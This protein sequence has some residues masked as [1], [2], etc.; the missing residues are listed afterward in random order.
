MADIFE[1]KQNFISRWLQKSLNRIEGGTYVAGPRSAENGGWPEAVPFDYVWS[2]GV[3]HSKVDGSMTMFFRTPDDVRT[4]WLNRKED[5]IHNQIFLNEVIEDLA[6]RLGQGTKSTTKDKRR[7][8]SLNIIRSPYKGLHW[9]K[10]DTAA[11]IDYRERM[12]QNLH[13]PEWSSYFGIELLPSGAMEDAASLQG[14]KQSMAERYADPL[15]PY[16]ADLKMVRALMVEDRGFEPLSNFGV[17]SRDYQLLTSWHGVDIEP[18]RANKNLATTRFQEPVDGYSLITPAWGEISFYAAV[19]TKERSDFGEDPLSTAAHWGKELYNPSNDVVG[20]WIKGEIRHRE[21][22][23]EVLNMKTLGRQAAWNKVNRERYAEVEAAERDLMVTKQ[24][25]QAAMQNDFIDNMEILVAV[26]DFV[27]TPNPLRKHLRQYGMDALLAVNRQADCLVAT[28][29]G[30]GKSISR[31][32]TG[33]GR[34][35]N[36]RRGVFSCQAFPGALS[37]SGILRR[38]KPAASNGILIGLTNRD[39]EYREVF[40][41]VDAAKKKNGS[42]VILVTGRTGSGKALSLQTPVCTPTGPVKLGDVH[43]GDIVLDVDGRPTVVT[44]ETE[45]YRAQAA[46]DVH[47][48]DGEVLVADSLHQWPVVGVEGGESLVD[49]ATRAMNA[50]PEGTVGTLEDIS[51]RISACGGVSGVWLTREALADSLAFIGCP[52]A[53]SEGMWPMREALASLVKRFRQ[54]TTI[55]SSKKGDFVKLSTMDLVRMAPHQS[56]VLVSGHRVGS[57]TPCAGSEAP[58]VKC[59][60]VDSPTCGFLVGE[61]VATGNTQSALQYITQVVYDGRPAIMLNPKAG[62]TLEAVFTHLGGVTIVINYEFLQENPGMLDPYNFFTETNKIGATLSDIISLSMGIGQGEGFK[63]RMMD[64]SIKADIMDNCR[65]SRNKTSYDVVYGNEVGRHHYPRLIKELNE[66]AKA[67]G[68]PEVKDGELSD[69]HKKYIRDALSVK[70]GTC[71]IFNKD[72]RDYLTSQQKVSPFWQSV[73]TDIP[74]PNSDL[75]EKLSSGKPVLIEWD[76]SLEMPDQDTDPKDYTAHHIESVVS[77]NLAFQYADELIYRQRAGGLL[78]VDEAWVLKGSREARNI[79]NR[80]AREWRQRNITLMLITQ[81]IQDYINKKSGNNAD[82]LSASIDRYVFMATPQADDV[83]RELFFSISGL[84][85]TDENWEYMYSA[86]VRNTDGAREKA[87]AEGYYVDRLYGFRGGILCGPWPVKELTL[88]RTDSEGEALR[89]KMLEDGF[90]SIS[91]D[92][93]EEAGYVM[94]PETFMDIVR[95]GEKN[96]EAHDFKEGGFEYTTTEGLDPLWAQEGSEDY[97]ETGA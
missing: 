89:K 70:G 14:F 21:V 16:M 62:S 85:N 46:Y 67:N 63:G 33:G 40:T 81:R 88:G 64:S 36:L 73:I 35:S 79:L 29:P 24:G 82:D 42:P 86:G 5:L 95:V 20:I 97:A 52:K 75:K 90:D 54:L 69:E 93:W 27:G 8:F 65:D 4:E 15:R 55:T 34:Q 58:M 96:T 71:P 23:K 72:V 22:I 91:D 10:S 6:E 43:V 41:E 3:F 25:E 83:E 66:R 37:M 68:D 9:D 28:I 31:V 1:G 2:N 76:G 77:V 50:E 30:S 32:K 56:L 49:A 18:F 87:V 61:G 84:E 60:S 53:D 94:S 17:D 74:N 19:P 11:T 57:V 26:Q 38:T 80:G 92:E 48:S 13:R 7:K 44:E 51:A 78:A 12:G 39:Y 59:I 47:L 45:D